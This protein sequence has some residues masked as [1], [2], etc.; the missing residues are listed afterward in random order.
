MG[1]QLGMAAGRD[2]APKNGGVAPDPPAILTG[3]APANMCKVLERPKIS[4]GRPSKPLPDCG[5]GG[6]VVKQPGGILSGLSF[7]AGQY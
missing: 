2:R 4:W 7:P 1:V 3:P 6:G 5:G